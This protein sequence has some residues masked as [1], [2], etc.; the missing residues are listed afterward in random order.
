MTLEAEPGDQPAQG[1]EHRLDPVEREVLVRLVGLL[2][3]AGAQ[4]HGL[5]AEPVQQRPLGAEVD[6]AGGVAG[7]RTSSARRSR[8]GGREAMTAL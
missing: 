7:W 5:A 1:I 3:V 2:D 4:D 8:S 6:R